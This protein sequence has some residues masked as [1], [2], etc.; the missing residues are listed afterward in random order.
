MARKHAIKVNPERQRKRFTRESR[1]EAVRLLQLR[2][3]PATQMA[4]EPGVRLSQLSN[5]WRSSMPESGCMFD[6][7][8]YG[9]PS[10]SAS[11]GIQLGNLALRGERGVFRVSGTDM[12]RLRWNPFFAYVQSR[13][14]TF[15]RLGDS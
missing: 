4:L 11:P 12:L 10:A 13:T 8:V 9:G 6:D 2:Q 3:K 7:S 14:L 15:M 1:L 5:Y